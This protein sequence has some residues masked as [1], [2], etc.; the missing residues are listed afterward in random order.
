MGVEIERKFL[1]LGNAWRS[2]AVGTRFC[3]GYILSGAGRTVRVR[4]AGDCAFLTIK[5]PLQGVSRAEYEYPIPLQDAQE[6]LDT[7]CDRPWI[8][9]VRYRIAYDNLTWEIDEFSG[10]NAGLVLAE[11]ELTTP[12][13]NIQL[14]DWVGVEVTGDPRYYNSSLV[15]YPY[16]DWP[17]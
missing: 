7:L 6:L 9:K 11:V 15:R 10:E 1:V 17:V 4:I 13:Q 3:Q 2:G 14:P 12:N 8:D 16:R 5:G